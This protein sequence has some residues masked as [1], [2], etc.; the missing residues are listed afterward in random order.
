[1]K[2]I[3]FLL[4]LF[5]ITFFSCDN[6][7][8]INKDPNN[9]AFDQVTPQKLLPAAQVGAYR[10]QATTMNQLGN[11]FMNSWTRNVQS[12]GN[13]FDREL[14]LNIDNAF[15]NG[16]WDGLYVELK[17][18]DAIAKF[19]NANG[20]YDNFVAAALVCKANYMGYIVDLYG[21]CPYSD[22]F[23]GIENT[24]PAYDN[25]EDIYKALIAELEEA[26]DLIINASPDAIDMSPYDVMLAGDMTRW[27][28]Y[29]NTIELRLLLRMSNVSG[30]LA[31]YRDDKLADISGGP[32]LTEGVSIN[33]GYSDA[34]DA[35]ANPLWNTFVRDVANNKRGNA[36]FITASG[37]AYKAMNSYA[38]TNYPAAGSQEIIAGS[39]VNYPNVADGRFNRLFSA[40]V[41]QPARRAVNQ[42]NTTVDVST[43][44][45]P[46]PGLPSVIGNFAFTPYV[47]AIGSF[48]DFQYQDAYVMPYS[49]VCFMLAEAAVRYPSLFA[50]A[51]GY[52]D[53]G[54]TDDFAYKIL[55]MGSYLSTINTK[56]NFGFTASTTADEQLHAIMYQKWIALM[57]NHGI[58][59]Y[60]DY[61]RTGYPLTP[62]STTAT[63]T[64]KPYRLIYP[65]S[66][67]VA[68]TGNVPVVTQN[69]V[70]V[71][72]SF[73]PFWLQ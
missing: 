25:D 67:Y 47:N 13:G 7:L 11:V 40:G 60:I 12:Y 4:P 49:Q 16:I 59:S 63:K 38:N 10:V 21:D 56:P 48:N 18:F 51:Q 50:D 58:E 5:A 41:G 8:D 2:K 65:V 62:L 3:K 39:G 73:S 9:L 64:R 55:N 1:M 46:M 45:A 34:T 52:F 20:E 15:Y 27:Y 71:I 68:N 37:H 61:T 57:S 42:G 23:K 70:F 14:Q 72:N 66:E 36:L 17:N 69:D 22:A 53:L 33:P 43:P 26:K 44:T 24:T 30:A 32:F 29:A 54:V 28:E 31:T 6:Y 35:N 19:S